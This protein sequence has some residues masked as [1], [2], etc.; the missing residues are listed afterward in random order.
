MENIANFHISTRALQLSSIRHPIYGFTS[1]FYV[2][3]HDQVPIELDNNHA[4]TV[5]DTGDACVYDGFG[6]ETD[7][8]RFCT[9]NLF[10]AMDYRAD[11][12]NIPKPHLV[13]SGASKPGCEWHDEEERK[14]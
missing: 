9:L 11:G 14:E 12:L 10:G 7:V 5:H 4:K 3:S 8:K 6:K 13:F 1:P 2:F